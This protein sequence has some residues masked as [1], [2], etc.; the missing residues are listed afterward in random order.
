M[1][2]FDEIID[3]RGSNCVKWDRAKADVLP[4]WVAD[5]DFKASE[6]IIE[7]VKARAN[8]GIFGYTLHSE[9][10]Y[11]AI[12]NW[13]NRKHNWQLEK[14]WILYCQG[15]VPA[16]AFIIDTLTESGD[17]VI[18]QSPVYYPFYRV[19][20]NNGCQVVNNPLDLKNGKYEIDFESF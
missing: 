12:I 20:T 13:W 17:K 15:V 10:Y 7:A 19:I 8:N 5:M 2:N 6:P 3:R 14:E 11:N 16:M 4:M 9:D 18:L 1:Y